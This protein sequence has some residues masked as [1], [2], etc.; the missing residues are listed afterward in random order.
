MLT[1]EIGGEGFGRGFKERE[2]EV[3]AGVERECVK[4]IR[5]CKLRGTASSSE[6][7]ALLFWDRS[8]RSTIK[9]RRRKGRW[10]GE[11]TF[12]WRG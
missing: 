5:R 9:K 7:W 1:E 6:S 8:K 4:K 12:A 11:M 10:K 2:A 3:K